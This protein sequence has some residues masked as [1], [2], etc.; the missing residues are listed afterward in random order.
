MIYAYVGFLQD[1]FNGIYSIKC[2]VVLSTGSHDVHTS[3]K[4]LHLQYPEKPIRF[5]PPLFKTGAKH[6]F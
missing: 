5:A 6:L 3:F 4:T 2:A 1:G